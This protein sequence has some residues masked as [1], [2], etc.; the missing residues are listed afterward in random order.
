MIMIHR[1]K[2]VIT[3]FKSTQYKD[4]CRYYVSTY[5]RRE[6]SILFGGIA[7]GVYCYENITFLDSVDRFKIG[8]TIIFSKK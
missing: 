2:N 6:K 4:I 1:K 3:S 5:G 7:G 8:D